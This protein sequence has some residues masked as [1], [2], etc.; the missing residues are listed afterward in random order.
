MNL[1]M[2]ESDKFTFKV[3]LQV[4]ALGLNVYPE[5]FTIVEA[6]E[7]DLSG[8]SGWPNVE[9]VTGETTVAEWAKFWRSWFGSRM[10]MP[11]VATLEEM[12]DTIFESINVLEI[13]G[14]STG[15]K[16]A[17][18]Y[19]P[20]DGIPQTPAFV[21]IV[22]SPEEKVLCPEEKI[23]VLRA[24]L[25][26]LVGQVEFIGLGKCM[27]FDPIIDRANKALDATK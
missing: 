14:Q 18:R 16:Q 4:E 12:K 2:K 10:E 5:G 3:E 27:V 26:E 19:D 17:G 23:K 22:D 20:R 24:S 13:N 9:I 21:T 15:S 7:S 11:K 1:P 25:T 6:Y 8:S